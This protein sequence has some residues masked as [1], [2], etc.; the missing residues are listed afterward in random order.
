MHYHY[1]QVF[2]KVV[3]QRNLPTPEEEENSG[4]VW[5]LDS[6]LL[7]ILQIVTVVV[8]IIAM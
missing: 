2:A 1:L 5:F 4:D 6:E 8:F 3:L 7:Q